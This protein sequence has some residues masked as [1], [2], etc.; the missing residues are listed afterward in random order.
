MAKTYVEVLSGASS[1]LEAAGKEGFAIEYL[2][3]ERKGWDKTQ[4]LMHMREE[5]SEEEQRVI[6][7]DLD[8]LMLDIPPSYMLGY[9]YFL[10]H[11][12]KVNQ[13]T[14][15][16]RPETEELVM[17]CLEMSSVSSPLRVVD[18][19]TGTGAIAI[20][21]K[22]A[23]P[24]WTVT[25]LDISADALAVA[26]ENAQL[27]GA[28][29]TFYQSDVLN[30]VNEPQDIIISNP[31]YISKDEWSLMDQSVRKYEPKGAL[32]AEKDGLAVYQRIAQEG[33]AL[34]KPTGMLFL[35][36][37]FQQGKAV[38]EMM[39][40]AFP[41]KSVTVRKDLSGNDRIV[42]VSNMQ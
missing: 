4:W 9:S 26:K 29:I 31:P 27:L 40:Q 3:L 19:G 30:A 14:L 7:S 16:P 25:G 17:T 1:F 37:G 42:V 34:L 15:I 8:Q 6:K 21:L 39:Q 10:N 41:D 5:I 28:E 38:K 12:L 36:I 2:F 32:F 11:R 18:I 35:E 20:S 22:L 23:R 24:N 33:P 13:H